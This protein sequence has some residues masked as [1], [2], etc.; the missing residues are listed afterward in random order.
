MRVPAGT[1]RLLPRELQRPA[2][3]PVPAPV[4]RQSRRFDDH[5]RVDGNE[6][7]LDEH[8]QKLLVNLTNAG[9]PYGFAASD[10]AQFVS[11]FFGARTAERLVTDLVSHWPRH[12]SDGARSLVDSIPIADNL[13]RFDLVVL[14]ADVSVNLEIMPHVLDRLTRTATLLLRGRDNR[15]VA[16]LVA[17]AHDRARIE[18]LPDENE[19]VRLTLDWA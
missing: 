13:G 17:A 19:L 12:T 11:A 8:Q 4:Q 7:R 18:D 3:V 15:A 5:E 6:S 1:R 9:N 14:D 2:R 10:R 16:T